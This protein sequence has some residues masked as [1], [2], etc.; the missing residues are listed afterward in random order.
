MIILLSNRLP[1]A[2]E[3]ER[4]MCVCVCVCVGVYDEKIKLTELYTYITDLDI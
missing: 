1:L 3:T 4:L 2:S